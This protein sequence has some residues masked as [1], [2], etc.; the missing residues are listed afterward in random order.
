MNHLITVGSAMK[1]MNNLIEK[2]KNCEVDYRRFMLNCLIPILINAISNVNWIVLHLPKNMADEIILV[3]GVP[4][5]LFS[6]DI[7]NF[8]KVGKKDMKAFMLGT[9]KDFVL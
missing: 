6:N 7:R 8:R 4:D 5:M 2:Y 1:K 3:L 9:A